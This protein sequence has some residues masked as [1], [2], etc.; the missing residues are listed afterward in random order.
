MGAS[1]SPLSLVRT[2]SPYALG[3]RYRLSTCKSEEYRA[4]W[5]AAQDY[6]INLCECVNSGVV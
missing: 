4:L 6:L 1:A 3:D 2:M 5:A